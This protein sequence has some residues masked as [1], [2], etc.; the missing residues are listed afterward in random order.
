[1]SK[2]TC[3]EWHVYPL[4]GKV[5]ANGSRIANVFGATEFNR[6]Q[7]ASECQANAR[8]ILNAPKMYTALQATFDRLGY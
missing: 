6:E 4:T 5:H 7:N 2:F 8:L 1:M 3:G